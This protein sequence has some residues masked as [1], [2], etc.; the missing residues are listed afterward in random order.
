MSYL[1]YLVFLMLTLSA[2]FILGQ[3]DR[4]E[5]FGGQ[6]VRLSCQEQ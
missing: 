4:C 6:W 1:I 3:R 5:D 2:F